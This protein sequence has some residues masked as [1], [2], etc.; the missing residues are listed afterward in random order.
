MLS[1][2]F[3]QMLPCSFQSFLCLSVSQGGTVRIQNYH[4]GTK[5]E[6][7]LSVSVFLF[8]PGDV[9]AAL[10]RWSVPVKFASDQRKNFGFGDLA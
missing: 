6:N 9:L 1:G 2:G 5:E 10:S 4:L 8:W 3:L 7:V